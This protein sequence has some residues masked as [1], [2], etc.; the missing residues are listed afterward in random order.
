[1]YDLTVL[2]F[3]FFVLIKGLAS[4]LHYV[5]VHTAILD[6]GA[7]CIVSLR[8]TTSSSRIHECVLVLFGVNYP[9]IRTL[10]LKSTMRW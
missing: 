9:D 7:R 5:I 10:L 3:V 4:L 1:M 8:V 6:V 2:I